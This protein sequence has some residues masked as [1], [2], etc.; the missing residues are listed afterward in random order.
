M[1]SAG[2]DKAA[3]CPEEVIPPTFGGSTRFKRE[4]ANFQHLQLSLGLLDKPLGIW[5]IFFQ[6]EAWTTVYVPT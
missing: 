6:N 4:R 2:A 1:R 5:Q 3:Y